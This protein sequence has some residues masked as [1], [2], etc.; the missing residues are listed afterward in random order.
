MHCWLL[1][2]IDYQTAR[3]T[4]IPT[5]ALQGDFNTN[6]F[7]KK[8]FDQVYN[9]TPLFLQKHHT[10]NYYPDIFGIAHVDIILLTLHIL[11]LRS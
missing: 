11:L 4:V 8:R 5:L 10:S 6:A 9:F 2:V 1:G 7:K 3:E